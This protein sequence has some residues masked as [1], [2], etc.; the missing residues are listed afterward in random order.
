MQVLRGALSIN[1]GTIQEHAGFQAF[2]FCYRDPLSVAEF[3][4]S[5]VLCSSEWILVDFNDTR[6]HCF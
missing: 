2:L 5:H 4:G 3:T 1:T 6:C